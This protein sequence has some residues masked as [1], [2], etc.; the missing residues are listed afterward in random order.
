MVDIDP[1]F[2]G[3]RERSEGEGEGAG[4]GWE[5]KGTERRKKALQ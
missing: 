3:P 5:E 4:R 1:L 2:P